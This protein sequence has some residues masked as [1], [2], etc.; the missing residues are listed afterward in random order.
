MVLSLQGEE[1]H[2]LKCRRCNAILGNVMIEDASFNLLEFINVTSIH[3]YKH[4]ISLRH[5]NLFRYV[6]VSFT[7]L[8]SLPPYY[9]V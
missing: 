8:G 6:Y 5:S 2:L 4:K 3:F 9:L 1:L 7:F